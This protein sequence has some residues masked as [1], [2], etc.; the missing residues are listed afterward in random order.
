MAAPVPVP[1]TGLRTVLGEVIRTKAGIV[2][3]SM[4]A[5]LIALVLVA[6]LTGRADGTTALG[7]TI[8]FWARAA[9]ALI[10]V[11][12][13]AYLRTAAFAVSLVGE[14]MILSRLLG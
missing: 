3:F 1:V 7:A 10:Y 13:V 12:G 2:G 11:A 4:L 6:H 5:F 14:G 9:H 8:F